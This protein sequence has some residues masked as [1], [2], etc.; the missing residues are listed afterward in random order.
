MVSELFSGEKQCTATKTPQSIIVNARMPVLQLLRPLF[1]S[2][3]FRNH[4][5]AQGMRELEF[6]LQL[7][8]KPHTTAGMLPGLIEEMKI[9]MRRE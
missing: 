4:I 5:I 7:V 2:Q 9:K 1:M 8:P 3:K 6:R